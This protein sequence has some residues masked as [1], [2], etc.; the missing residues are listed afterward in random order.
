MTLPAKIVGGYLALPVWKPERVFNLARLEV[1]IEDDIP[2]DDPK[3]GRT[4]VAPV[5]TQ[6]WVA[7]TDEDPYVCVGEVVLEPGE[8]RASASCEFVNG[9]GFDDVVRI[10]STA[11]VVVV[12]DAVWIDV[13]L[14]PDPDINVDSKPQVDL[15]PLG[16]FL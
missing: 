13:T 6:M 5:T 16:T 7:E 12:T 4:Y 3:A 8:Y 10:P 14:S 9:F 11:K 1:N 2:G 15:K